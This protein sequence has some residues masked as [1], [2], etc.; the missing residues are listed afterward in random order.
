MAVFFPRLLR[1]RA[2]F[3]AL[4]ASLRFSFGVPVNTEPRI[5]TVADATVSGPRSKFFAAR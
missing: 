1:S 3:S 5:G 2:T 4:S